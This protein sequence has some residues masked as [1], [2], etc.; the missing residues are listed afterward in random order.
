[1]LPCVTGLACC[2][3]HLASLTD[4]GE[5]VAFT[6]IGPV[7]LKGVP[8]TLRLQIAAAT[9]EGHSIGLSGALVSEGAA[10]APVFTA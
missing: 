7:E 6:D 10:S 9:R 2:P 1:M 5:P 4:E 3:R 8:G